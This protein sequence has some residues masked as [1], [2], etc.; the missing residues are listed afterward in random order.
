MVI[1]GHILA[2]STSHSGLIVKDILARCLRRFGSSMSTPSPPPK[3]LLESNQLTEPNSSMRCNIP[4]I[5]NDTARETSSLF[6]LLKA[7]WRLLL[8]YGRTMNGPK[9]IGAVAF[10]QNYCATRHI[11]AF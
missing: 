1:A 6:S 5:Y 11:F 9:R 10:L 7:Q 4:R 2:L 3:G 8:E